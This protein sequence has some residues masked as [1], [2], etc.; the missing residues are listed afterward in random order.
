[1]ADYPAKI[2]LKESLILPSNKN[3]KDTV[4]LLFFYVLRIS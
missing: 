4:G 3:S 1:M 2:K